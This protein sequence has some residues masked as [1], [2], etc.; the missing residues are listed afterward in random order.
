MTT[1]DDNSFG[2]SDWLACQHDHIIDAL[3]GPGRI[4]LPDALPPALTQALHQE[5]QQQFDAGAFHAAAIGRGHNE[6]VNHSIRGDS[7]CWLSEALPAASAYLNALHTL[8]QILNR[9]LYLGLDDYEAHY[10]HYEP[11]SFYRRHLDRHHNSDARRV[12]TVCYLDND[13]Q[14]DQGGELLI[15]ESLDTDMPVQ[16]VLPQSGT[17]VLFMSGDFP[18]EVLPATRTRHSIAGWLRRS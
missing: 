15:Y 5:L 17:L 9:T 4:V 7:L 13:W 8:R 12:T 18:H 11:G 10:A 2:D 14:H 6:Q 3:T 1:G 16:R